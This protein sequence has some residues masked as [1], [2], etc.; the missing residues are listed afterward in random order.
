MEVESE[1]KFEVV[2]RR[3]ARSPKQEYM[4]LS[5]EELKSQ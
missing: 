1:D 2:R 3:R 4:L 5:E